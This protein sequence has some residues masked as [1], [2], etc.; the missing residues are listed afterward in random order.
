MAMEQAR[1]RARRL[2]T[3]THRATSA[4]CSSSAARQAASV[5]SPSPIDAGIALTRPGFQKSNKQSKLDE[6]KRAPCLPKGYPSQPQQITQETVAYRFSVYYT[7]ILHS[8]CAA[9]KP[10]GFAQYCKL[11]LETSG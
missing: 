7:A 3:A 4:I 2:R 9:R 5:G 11:H 10:Q 8:N 1:P 6:V